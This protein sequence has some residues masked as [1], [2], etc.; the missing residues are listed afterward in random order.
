MESITVLTGIQYIL[1]G[2]QTYSMESNFNF[3]GK[4]LTQYV[5]EEESLFHEY[6][7]ESGIHT[8][9]NP[10]CIHRNTVRN[11]YLY[12]QEYLAQEYS[13]LFIPA[14]TGIQYRIYIIIIYVHCLHS[15]DSI[16]YSC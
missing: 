10:H 13:M 8:I 1:T 11:P 9:W 6:L 4:D 5:I 16:L 15:V 7:T 3:N 2:K 12:S 14:F